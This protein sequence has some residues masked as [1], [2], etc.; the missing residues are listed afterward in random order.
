LSPF[1]AAGWYSTHIQLARAESGGVPVPV[2]RCGL[3]IN[4]REM[5]MDVDIPIV[6]SLPLP[7]FDK[8]RLLS[9]TC[10]TLSTGLN[11]QSNCV[12]IHLNLTFFLTGSSQCCH[13]LSTM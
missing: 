11:S 13:H 8:K 1:R 4:L 10:L 3:Y 12:L 9:P 6:V 7:N 2:P 5:G